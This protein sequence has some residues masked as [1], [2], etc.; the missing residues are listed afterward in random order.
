MCVLPTTFLSRRASKS[1]L[2]L[3]HIVVPP[4]VLHLLAEGPWESYLIYVS[5]FPHL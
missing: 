5:L 4:Y 1:A 3:F 2:R